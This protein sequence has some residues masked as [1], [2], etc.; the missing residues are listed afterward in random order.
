MFEL[1]RPSGRLFYWLLSA[2]MMTATA[3]AQG[4]ATTTIAESMFN[5]RTGS[6]KRDAAMSFVEAAISMGD[7]LA[8][9]QIVDADKFKTGLGKVIDGAVECLNASVWAKK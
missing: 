8:N 5:G 1:R 6:D 4:P 2:A 7:A 3:E 9:G